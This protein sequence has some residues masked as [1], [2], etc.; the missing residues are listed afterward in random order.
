[1]NQTIF[2]LLGVLGLVGIGA[3]MSSNDDDHPPEG[4]GDDPRLHPDTVMASLAVR[5]TTPSM[6]GMATIWSGLV[7]AMTA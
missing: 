5:A 3:L 1:M 4:P 7:T 6:V 2:L